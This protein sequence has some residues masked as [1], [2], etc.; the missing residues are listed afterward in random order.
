MRYI[1]EEPVSGQWWC[2]WTPEMVERARRAARFCLHITPADVER[3]L[4]CE[5]VNY[6]VPPGDFLSEPQDA[7]GLP[8]SYCERYEAEHEDWP[9][10]C[11]EIY[12]Y[13][14]VPDIVVNDGRDDRPYNSYHRILQA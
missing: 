11:M 1:N 13:D 8:L 4:K 14:S 9:E 5:Q 2:P 10:C 6:R 7:R 3:V 12:D